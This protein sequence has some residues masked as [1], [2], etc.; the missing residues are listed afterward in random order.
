MCKLQQQFGVRVKELRAR[1][2]M[3][4]EE[5]A[6]TIDLDRSYLASVEAGHRNISLRNI[7]KI[8]VGLGVSISELMEGVGDHA[9]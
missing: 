5:F 1:L 6:S 7:S 8:A 3:S 2:S 9:Q 4:Q